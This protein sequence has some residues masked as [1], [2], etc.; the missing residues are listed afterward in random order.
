MTAPWVTLD[1]TVNPL[2]PSA[3]ATLVSTVALV[4]WARVAH[5]AFALLVT[6][7]RTTTAENTPDAIRC[8][9]KTVRE[10]T[11]L[12]A[13]AERKSLQSLRPISSLL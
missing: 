7:T 11:D 10:Q 5:C 1:E 12:T 4:S 13:P 8:L 9:V 2:L 3:R 6:L